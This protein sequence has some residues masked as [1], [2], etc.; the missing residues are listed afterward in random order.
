M[1]DDVS[2]RT[3]LHAAA[4]AAPV[5]AVVVAT[6]LSA[7]SNAR[8]SS[9]G[10]EVFFEPSTISAPLGESSV[11]VDLVVRNTGTVATGAVQVVLTY[12]EPE[13]AVTGP[14]SGVPSGAAR[15]LS[16]VTDGTGSLTVSSA[17]LAPGESAGAILRADSSTD[18]PFD[19]IVV[20]VASA[21]S[22]EFSN[23]QATLSYSKSA[24]G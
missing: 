5:I 8:A 10:L 19:A 23:N 24:L 6:P 18:Q 2:R 9:T 1:T 14:Y 15:P 21:A 17:S 22:E 7:A 13:L 3:V 12:T 16:Y 20:A 11:R 4:W